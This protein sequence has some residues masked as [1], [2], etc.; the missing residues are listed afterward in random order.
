MNDQNFLFSNH[1][2]RA[3]STRYYASVIKF[4]LVIKAPV[5][6]SNTNKPNYF[7]IMSIF[8][9]INS[10]RVTQGIFLSL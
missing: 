10:V 5:L 7:N 3:L 8:C 2:S 9:K 6:V 1:I 4:P